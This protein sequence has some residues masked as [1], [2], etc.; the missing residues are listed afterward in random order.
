MVQNQ[1]KMATSHKLINKHVIDY[2]R[3]VTYCPITTQ[4][5][6]QNDNASLVTHWQQPV[7]IT[8]NTILCQ[9]IFYDI[10]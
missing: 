3:L 5:N 7:T 10:S 9:Y 6:S 1:T 4:I 2:T 8:I